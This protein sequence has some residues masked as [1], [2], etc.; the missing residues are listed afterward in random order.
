MTRIPARAPAV[1]RSMSTPAVPTARPGVN[2]MRSG[3]GP[4]MRCRAAH[5]G[6]DPM[7]PA[8]F[9][10]AVSD[11]GPTQ[12]VLRQVRL[13]RGRSNLALVQH[14]VAVWVATV[15][16]VATG[17]VLVA[18]RGGRVAFALGALGGLA[19]VCPI[20]VLLLRRVSRRWLRL[21]DAP[22][23]I[24]T[25]RGLR[26]RLASL[27]ELEGRTRGDLF[28]L[29]VRQNRDALSRWQPEDVVP[30]VVPAR[31]FACAV[32]ALCALALVVVLAPKLRPPAPRIVVGDRPM[33]FV[34]TRDPLGGADRLLVAP[35][36]EHP[37]PSQ[38]GTDA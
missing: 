8:C 33:D 36:T 26:G 7:T 35:G 23:R 15:A 14:V 30:D 3:A 20:T 5:R 27:A 11:P 34:A 38:D 19:V 22:H 16:A 21:A 17:L 2:L 28:A 10:E 1:E 9:T 4:P 6:F 24:D 12:A 31:P 25:M 29:L 18:V 37:A 13:V 32:A